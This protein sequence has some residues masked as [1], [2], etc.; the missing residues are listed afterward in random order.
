MSVVS[1]ERKTSRAIKFFFF[2]F[3]MIMELEKERERR[4][5]ESNVQ[6]L[7]IGE[8]GRKTKQKHNMA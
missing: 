8:G 1:D 7:A 2:F 6:L 5:C 4:V 3:L